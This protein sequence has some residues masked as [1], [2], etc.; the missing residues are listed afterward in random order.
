M[1]VG[2]SGGAQMGNMA[3]NSPGLHP[4][5]PNMQ[6]VNMQRQTGMM[7][8]QGASGADAGMG[9]ARNSM[10]QLYPGMSSG[11]M[12]GGS[13]QTSGAQGAGNGTRDDIA[14]TG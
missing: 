12:N 14:G 10:G 8:S 6:N 2:V 13:S 11:M 9:G 7:P 5:N 4:M 3:F 1:G